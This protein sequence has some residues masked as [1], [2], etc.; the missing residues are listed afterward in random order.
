MAV[1]MFLKLEN[2]PGESMDQ[3][4]PDHIE[5]LSFSWG[6]TQHGAYGRGGS[7]GGSGKAAFQDVQ[8]THYY[9]KASTVLFQH[10]VNGKHIKSGEFIARKAGADGKQMDY[11]NLKIKDII[12]TSVSSGHTVG[13]DDRMVESF[14]LNFAEFD[15]TYTT[16]KADGTSQKSNP[17]KWNLLK[18]AEA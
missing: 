14:S 7:G 8:F 5:I 12:V 18:N 2:L 16:Q 15:V 9:D 17:V 11:L 1:D 6:V 10:C 3:K 13:G 4:L